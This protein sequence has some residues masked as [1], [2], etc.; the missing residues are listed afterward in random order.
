MKGSAS[1]RGARQNSEVPRLRGVEATVLEPR[2][3]PRSLEPYR[4][5]GPVGDCGVL[6]LA[7]ISFSL[8]T[9][10]CSSSSS[11]SQE[12]IF[13]IR[14]EPVHEREMVIRAKVAQQSPRIGNTDLMAQQ[15]QVSCVGQYLF[16]DAV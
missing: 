12:F 1:G 9:A 7:A 11:E 10:S 3:S 13:R 5:D 6:E 4:H 15:S 16:H 8:I 14:R 2:L